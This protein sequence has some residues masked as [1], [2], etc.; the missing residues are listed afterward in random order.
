M[1]TEKSNYIDGGLA[2]L[3]RMRDILTPHGIHITKV[4]TVGAK[5]V[6]LESPLANA[7]MPT[8]N[9]AAISLEVYVPVL[10]DSDS[11]SKVKNRS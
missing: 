8:G 5:D 11:S 10:V 7:G 3:A 6:E 4:S 2:A 9:C 1:S